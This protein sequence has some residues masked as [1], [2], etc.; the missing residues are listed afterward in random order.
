MK[1][2]VISG[3]KNEA[4]IIESFVRHNAKFIDDFYFIDDS[5]DNTREILKLLSAEGYQINLIN[6]DTRDYHQSKV[7]TSATQLI[8]QGKKYD[9]IFYLDG[10]EILY[11]PDK[12]SFEERIM[13]SGTS[14]VGVVRALDFI[15]TGKPYFSSL[16]PLKECFVEVPVRNPAPKIFI[17]GEISDKVIIG[18]GQHAAFTFDHKLY[19]SFE[20]G[21]AIGHFA[22]RS[23]EQFTSRV[24]TN[25]CSVL[26]KRDKI[27]GEASHVIQQFQDLKARDFKPDYENYRDGAN[28][29]TNT[30]V[31]LEDIVC[32]YSDLAAR[33]IIRELALDMERMALLLHQFRT[34]TQE[35]LGHIE[36]LL[37]LKTLI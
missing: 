30:P 32:R 20:T 5:T 13:A 28:I 3:V 19:D 9:F 16:N 34:G 17:K 14:S 27:P 1:L 2:A 10:D 8:N 24:V 12:H 29:Q 25:Y 21:I 23:Y 35:A 7:N 15:P 4:D 31:H 26:A 6:L 33:N 36:G 22:R 18:P 11:Y 37:K